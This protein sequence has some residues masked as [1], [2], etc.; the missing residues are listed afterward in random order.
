MKKISVIAVIVLFFWGSHSFIQMKSKKDNFIYDQQLPDTILVS[1]Y[2]GH[3]ITEFFVPYD[4]KPEMTC[5]LKGDWNQRIRRGDHYLA[6]GDWDGPERTYGFMALCLGEALFHMPIRKSAKCADCH[7]K[8]GTGHEPH[9]RGGGRTVEKENMLHF[10]LSSNKPKVQEDHK[11]ERKN[12][13]ILNAWRFQRTKR[14]LAVGFESDNPLQLQ[15]EKA[16]DAHFFQAMLPIAQA[17]LDMQDASWLLFGRE[18]DTE[19][20]ACCLAVFQQ[21]RMGTSEN[22]INAILRGAD[23]EIQNEKGLDLFMNKK[24]NSCHMNGIMANPRVEGDLDLVLTPWLDDNKRYHPTF[25]FTGVRI[26]MSEAVKRCDF[27][28]VEDMN[29]DTLAAQGVVPDLTWA[30]PMGYW[31]RRNLIGFMNECLVDRRHI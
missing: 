8:S 31:D 25:F 9:A 13:T 12:R 15:V 19:I 21:V 11:L 10:A 28:L 4:I 5:E 20:I 7:N 1:E 6:P 14:I 16:T 18:I 3:D 24:C 23:V 30:R 22:K 29:S 17:N 27:A 2:N 26:S